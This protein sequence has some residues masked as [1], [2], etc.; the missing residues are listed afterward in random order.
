MLTPQSL[1][2]LVPILALMIPIVAILA[3]HQ[4]KMAEIVHQ[5]A[6]GHESSQEIAALR[7]EIQELK[8]LVHQQAIVLDDAKSS[9][10]SSLENRLGGG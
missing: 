8:A 1:V 3:A 4:R 7:Q 5:S 10:A 9:R 6:R 2:F